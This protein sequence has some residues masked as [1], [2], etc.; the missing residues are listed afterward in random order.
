LSLVLP[1]LVM[2]PRSEPQKSFPS[3]QIARFSLARNGRAAKSARV[4]GLRQS[5]SRQYYRLPPWKVKVSI[6]IHRSGW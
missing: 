1:E 5:L 4:V 3:P 2:N 6:D